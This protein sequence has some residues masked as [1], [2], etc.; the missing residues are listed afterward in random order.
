MA[1]IPPRSVMGPPQR[2]PKSGANKSPTSRFNRIRVGDAMKKLSFG[3]AAFAAAIAASAVSAADLPGAPAYKAPVAVP[4]AYSW[5]GCYVGVEG[6]ANFGRSRHTSAGSGGGPA[7]DITPEFNLSGGLVGGEFG[8]N[9]QVGGFVFGIEGDGSWTNK[10]GSANNILPFNAAASETHEKTLWTARGRIGYAWDR[11]LFYVTG[12]GAWANAG[13]TVTGP[14]ATAT[15]DRTIG[16]WTA[17]G[18]VEWAVWQSLTAKVE[19]LYVD[20]GN[21]AF[22]NPPPAANFADRAGGIHLVDHVVRAGLSWHFGPNG[23]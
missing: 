5:T 4:V 2:F 15:E 22:F 19:Y 14:G 8:C 21:P 16:G 9:Y 23:Y 1:Q 13:I 17:G 11:V 6:G 3:T 12:G 7:G 10:K 20:F 18:G